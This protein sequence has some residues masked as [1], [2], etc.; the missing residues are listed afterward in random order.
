M[1]YEE[2]LKKID[3]LAK[4]T[5]NL[6][7]DDVPSEIQSNAQRSLYRNLGK[8]EKL[9]I[10]IDKAIYSSRHADWRGNPPSEILI[11]QAIFKLLKDKNEVERIFQI[12]KQQNEY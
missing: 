7:R 4:R 3:E 6:A 5:T 9:A 10:S 12:V 8:N 1:S 11:K 2:Y